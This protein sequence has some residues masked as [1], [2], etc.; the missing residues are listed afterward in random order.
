VTIQRITVTHVGGVP[1]EQTAIT[2]RKLDGTAYRLT[3]YEMQDARLVWVH[4]YRESGRL[5]MYASLT[6]DECDA[7]S[8]A[9]I[10]GNKTSDAISATS[11]GGGNP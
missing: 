9:W 5:R 2:F 4:G 8:L 11:S 10:A 6:P 1:L 7:Y 3:H